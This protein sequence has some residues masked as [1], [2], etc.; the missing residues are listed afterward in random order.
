MRTFA[1]FGIT[2]KS[3]AS[4]E[5]KTICPQCSARRT[6]KNYPCLN[7]NVDKGVWHCWHCEW[8]GTLKDGEDK[9]SVTYIQPKVFKKPQFTPSALPQSVVDWFAGRGITSAVL[10]RNRIA[11]S[12]VYFPQIEDE[13]TAIRFPFYRDGE[14]V[15]IKSRDGRKNFRMEGGAERLLYKLDD[16]AETTI[17]V[18]GEI[19]ALSCEEAGFKECVSVPDGAPAANTKDYSSKFN[20]LADERLETVKHWIIAVD[21]DEPGKKLEEELSR[22]LGIEKCSRVTWPQGCKDANDVLVK[23]G[24]ETLYDCIKE[25]KP[26]PVE[27]IFSIFDVAE[28]VDVLYRDGLPKG[29][30]TGWRS[31][32][33][34]YRVLPG[35]WTLVTGIPGH[36]KSE[37]LDGL[38]VN[39]AAANGWSIA[40]F[41]AENQPLEFHVSKLAEKYLGKPFNTGP[42]ERMTVDELAS[43]KKWVGEH[44]YFIYPAEPTLDAILNRAKVLVTRNGIR[45]LVIDPWNEIQHDRKDGVSETEHISLSLSKIRKFARAHNV[46]VWI[47]A[48]PK[49]LQKEKDG[50][51]PVPTPYDVS[52]SAHWRNK[53]D[54][55]IAVWRD[56]KKSESR[57]VFVHVQKIRFRW[58]GQI[59]CATLLWDKVTG[60]YFDEASRAAPVYQHFGESPL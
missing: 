16:L 57:E 2:V 19:D 49:Q 35:L 29:Q 37:W 7:V 47:V 17:I 30:S 58:T 48:H 27:G 36:G 31:V 60:R 23:H 50:D 40:I 41:S 33:A 51:Y 5:V 54:Q 14:V 13:A 32:D 34:Y 8:A 56:Q 11:Y 53:A 3:G 42:T 44:F 24:K 45:G 4:G 26:Y 52:G 10:E 39:L 1:E 18:E 46:H 12:S 55:C 21:N 22:R 15:N 43:A 9:K 59:G 25:A 38:C 28:N 6:K 20:F